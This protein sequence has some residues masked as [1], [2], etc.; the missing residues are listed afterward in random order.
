MDAE[1]VARQAK[2]I[3]SRRKAL[4]WLDERGS[5]MTGHD[6]DYE[7]SFSMKLMFAASCPGASEATEMMQAYAR[8]HL[9]AIVKSAIECCRNDIA[10][11]REAIET[12]LASIDA[13][14]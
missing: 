5:K 11:A 3:D 7:T 14:P 4:A 6:D 9:P 13:S 8:A 10:I 1:K 12:E 2:K